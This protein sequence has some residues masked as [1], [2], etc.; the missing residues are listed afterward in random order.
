M[1]NLPMYGKLLGIVWNWTAPLR[2]SVGS[3]RFSSNRNTL[4][5]LKFLQ[6]PIIFFAHH[7]GYVITY[8]DMFE[9]DFFSDNNI[10]IFLLALA[11]SPVNCQTCIVFSFPLNIVWAHHYFIN[12]AFWIR[13]RSQFE[14]WALMDIQLFSWK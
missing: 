11:G 6:C 10:T 13:T 9:E 5:S 4:A 2:K 1:I 8:I 3:E 7:L 14:S 12:F